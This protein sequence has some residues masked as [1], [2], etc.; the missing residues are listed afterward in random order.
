MKTTLDPFEKYKKEYW[1]K[2]TKKERKGEIL[3]AINDLTGMHKKSIS[4]KFKRLQLTDTAAKKA[5]PV[6]QGR[7]RI[8]DF[9]TITALK[10]LWE[11]GEKVCAE[12]LHP[13]IAE[14][15]EQLRKNNFWKYEKEIEEKLLQ[16]SLS[17][18]KRKVGEFFRKDKDSFRKG[19]ST[20]KPASIKTIIPIRD[21]SWFEAKIGEGQLDTV[22]HSGDS[23]TGEMA[24]TL[25]FTDYVTYWIGL[26]AQMGKGQIATQKSLFQIKKELPFEML[27]IHPDT[28]SEFINY[29]LKSCCDNIGVRMTR[30]RPN[31]KN[32]NMCV[33]ERN[34]HIIRKKV[35]YIRIDCKE[36][37]AVLNDYYFVLCL[38]ANHFVAVRRTKAKV[39]IGS[40]YQRTFEE[41]KTP[42][43]RVM[44]SEEISKEQ[45]EK[46]K[47]IHNYLNMINL[48]TEMKRLLDEVKVIQKKVRGRLY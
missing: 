44:E 6:K 34:G 46:L 39:R 17:T 2:K 14:Y 30:S 33:E 9:K 25:N 4:R 19:K 26:R 42:Y 10:R 38:F 43:Q 5:L 29:H 22:V 8:Y 16:M 15:I 11:L 32:D 24:Y 20:T 12:L 28:G 45:K 7:P 23:L 35:G 31:H 27:E 1:K 18:V 37:V 13:M 48:Q 21:T 36:A 3:K 47:K 41:A 40:R